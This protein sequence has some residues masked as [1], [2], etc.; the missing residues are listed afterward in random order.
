MTKTLT[1]LSDREYLQV[2]EFIRL[3]GASGSDEERVWCGYI[4]KAM[5]LT[6]ERDPNNRQWVFHMK[7]DVVK[8]LLRM[9]GPD[10]TVDF[11][12]I[13]ALTTNT[14]DYYP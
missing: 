3:K 8:L 4:K 5:A 6:G 14:F 11:E 13:H 10:E 12:L 9:M 1:V 7:K 2:L